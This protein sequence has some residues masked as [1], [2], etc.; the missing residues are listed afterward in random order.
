MSDLLQT[1]L[2]SFETVQTKA[3]EY[4][5]TV[6]Q[7]YQHKA[8]RSLIHE[9]DTFF[10]KELINIVELYDGKVQLLSR[11]WHV[12]GCGTEVDFQ[13]WA[14]VV[15]DLKKAMNLLVFPVSPPPPFITQ[16]CLRSTELPR[17]HFQ[18]IEMPGLI[19]LE[20]R[21]QIMSIV[22]HRVTTYREVEEKM[23]E[24]RQKVPDIVRNDQGD[25][26]K[27]YVRIGYDKSRGKWILD[28]DGNSV[29]R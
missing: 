9:L 18:K 7:T 3:L 12:R 14:S 5:E 15:E 1:N 24:L 11:T 6:V 25:S 16:E 22:E 27:T 13:C 8:T 23:R 2:Y 29:W 4:P 28:V 20:P 10:P 26:Y 19:V 17:P 21:F